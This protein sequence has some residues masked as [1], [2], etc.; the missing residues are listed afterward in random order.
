MLLQKDRVEN[1]GQ[2]GKEISEI[3]EKEK[4]YRSASNQLWGY[5]KKWLP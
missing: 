2:F 1:I 5:G 3:L 4:Y